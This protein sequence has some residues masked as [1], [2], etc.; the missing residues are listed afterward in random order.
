MYKSP[1]ELNQYELH[2]NLHNKGNIETHYKSR[3]RKKIFFH[4]VWKKISETSRKFIKNVE[5]HSNKD[6]S[7]LGH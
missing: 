2:T 7:G 3:N 4:N 1:T 5:T 6:G